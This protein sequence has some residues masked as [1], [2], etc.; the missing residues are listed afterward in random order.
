MYL[1]ALKTQLTIKDK[2]SRPDAVC[3]MS[4]RP[5]SDVHLDVFE[6]KQHK[7][8]YHSFI[9]HPSPI[10]QWIC[11]VIFYLFHQYFVLC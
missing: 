9:Y 11:S 5:V 4:V 1:T 2:P 8:P 3:D 7:I 10:S 6:A